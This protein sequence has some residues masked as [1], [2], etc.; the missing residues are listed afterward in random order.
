MW[1]GTV[2]VW[3]WL[4]T[5][6][7]SMYG[8]HEIR[9]WS[10]DALVT[11]CCIR[12]SFAHIY[13]IFQLCI[14]FNRRNHTH[15]SLLRAIFKLTATVSIVITW[16]LVVSVVNRIRKIMNRIF[17]K[18]KRNNV[19]TLLVYWHSGHLSKKYLY[20]FKMGNNM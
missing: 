8:I 14:I 12:C 13:T 2:W 17:L 4:S 19:Y 15:F 10:C 3:S 18:K 20:S 1:S 6:S 16:Q 5:Y 7:L 11:S 9:L